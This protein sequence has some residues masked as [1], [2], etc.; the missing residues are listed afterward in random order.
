MRG[1]FEANRQQ[2]KLCPCLPISAPIDD[3]TT[4][5]TCS[6]RNPSRLT[7]AF[8]RYSRLTACCLLLGANIAVVAYS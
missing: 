1:G 2:N 6:L 5:I 3:T 8:P 7:F 4:A